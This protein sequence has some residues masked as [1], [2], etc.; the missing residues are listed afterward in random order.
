MAIL[1]TATKKEEVETGVSIISICEKLG[2][3]FGCTNGV[4][5]T[6]LTVVKKGM[7]YLGEKNDKEKA[8]GIADEERLMCQCQISGGEV[9]IEV[10]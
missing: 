8:M 2:V 1:K 10:F 9:E 4:C 3:P 5:G 7:E 6:C